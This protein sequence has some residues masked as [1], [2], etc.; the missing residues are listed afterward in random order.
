[1]TEQQQAPETPVVTDRGWAFVGTSRKAHYYDKDSFSVCGK[2]RALFVHKD[3][4][5]PETGPSP[6][7]CAGCRRRL[8]KRGVK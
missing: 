6:D 2:Y 4:F 7:D 5:E 3:A 8:D 1:M